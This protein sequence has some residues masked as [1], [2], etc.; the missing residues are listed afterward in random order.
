ML[1]NIR[2]LNNLVTNFAVR[3]T[4]TGLGRDYSALLA[5][6]SQLKAGVVGHILASSTHDQSTDETGQRFDNL[7]RHSYPTLVPS[8]FAKAV[9]SHI[10][11]QTLF[12]VK[13]DWYGAWLC[14]F[15]VFFCHLLWRS[16]SGGGVG[17]DGPWHEEDATAV[18]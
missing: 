8:L 5:R 6:A 14:A 7:N 10:N 13:T 3:V 16:C 2:S 17:Y 15:S 11:I 9:V 4:P 1:S 12:P 18:T